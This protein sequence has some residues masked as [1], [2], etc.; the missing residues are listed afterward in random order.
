MTEQKDK[1]AIFKTKED[2]LSSMGRGDVEIS[3]GVLK[4]PDFTSASNKEILGFIAESGSDY[5]IV[6]VKAVKNNPQAFVNLAF[7]KGEKSDTI[8][9]PA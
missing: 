3:K 1:I 8:Q 6:D 7:G 4:N 9:N 5:T 2:V